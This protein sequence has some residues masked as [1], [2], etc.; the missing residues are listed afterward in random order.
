MSQLNMQR[1]QINN[2]QRYMAMSRNCRLPGTPL[3]AYMTLAPSCV[4][5]VYR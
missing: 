4:R 3:V 5:V 2:M 1:Y